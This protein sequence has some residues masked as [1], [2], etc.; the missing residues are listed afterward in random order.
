MG[1]FTTYPISLLCVEDEPALQELLRRHLANAVDTF[2]LAGDGQEGYDL[3][4]EHHPDVVI[5]DL[6]MPNIGGLAMSRMIRVA[7]PKT[8][9]ILITSCNRADFLEEAIDIGVTQFLLKPVL[10]EKL[11]TSLERCHH[12]IELERRSNRTIKLE[13]LEIMA[14]G[15]AHSFNNILTAILG[16]VQLALMHLPQ[17][18]IPH[19]SIKQAETSANRAAEIVK[20]MLDYTAKGWFQGR[21]IDLNVLVKQVS[22][23]LLEMLPPEISLSLDAEAS[24]P[25]IKGELSQLRQVI[26]SLAANSMDAIGNQRGNI[27]ISTGTMVCDRSYIENCW[28]SDDI[29][30]GSYVF[31]EVS[32]TGCGMEKETLEKLFDPFF[33]TKFTGR[34]MGLAAVLGIIRWHKG[35]I[36]ITSKP[37]FGSEFRIILPTDV[38]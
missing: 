12:I 32:D 24:L 31:L 6:M 36:N 20:Q 28:N 15:F 27:T 13:S 10:K 26:S 16:N 8:P 29:L 7:A 2:Y 5:T 1:L 37:R 19:H 35:A 9:I 25:P 3:F 18:S 38:T 14:G 21:K 34:G 30:P 22:Q 11:L 33:S 17:D 23:S 4:N